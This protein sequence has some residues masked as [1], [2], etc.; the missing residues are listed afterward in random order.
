MCRAQVDRLDRRLKRRLGGHQHHGCRGV[1][2]SNGLE[3]VDATHLGHA[4]VREYEIRALLAEL[5]EPIRT[6]ERRKDLEP[7]LVQEDAQGLDDALLVIDQKDAWLL[8]HGTAPPPIG[9][10]RVSGW[11]VSLSRSSQ[12]ICKTVE[13]RGLTRI[14]L[15]RTCRIESGYEFLAAGFFEA[16]TRR[17]V[18]SW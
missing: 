5:L 14:A 13:R 9:H 3:H 7:L 1:A 17:S 12:P 8:A 6:G 4:N 16:L 2:L 10:T 11:L 18:P 15:C